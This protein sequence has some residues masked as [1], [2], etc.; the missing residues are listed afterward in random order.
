MFLVKPLLR[1]NYLAEVSLKSIEHTVGALHLFHFTA[2]FSMR[3]VPLN[4]L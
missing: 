1:G 2:C 4:E 3:C